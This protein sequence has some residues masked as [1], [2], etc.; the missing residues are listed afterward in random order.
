MA[1]SFSR[2]PRP[3]IVQAVPKLLVYSLPA[4]LP[5]TCASA[6]EDAGCAVTCCPGSIQA[7]G[8]ERAGGGGV[9]DN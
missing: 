6:P 3:P 9:E 4:L 7:K 2:H 1:P 5:R 8:K